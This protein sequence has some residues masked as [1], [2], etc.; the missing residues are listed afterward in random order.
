M[1]L[2]RGVPTTLATLGALVWATGAAPARAGQ[3]SK[4]PPPVE[5]G[6]QLWLENCWHCHGKRAL[7]DGPLAAAGPVAAP[8]LAG[9]VPDDPEPWM[10]AIHRGQRSMPAFGP[11]FDRSAARS[12]L[13]WLGELDPE[14]GEGPSIED[15]EKSDDKDDETDGAETTEGNAPDVDGPSDGDE[16][17]AGDDP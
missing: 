4:L 1:R 9:R 7:G 15:D 12:I 16:A 6:E 14:T 11:V 2:W 17:P 10:L 8:P 13:T 5:R 3:S